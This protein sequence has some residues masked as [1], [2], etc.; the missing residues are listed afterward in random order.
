MVRR[1]T[2][3]S[4]LKDVGQAQERAIEVLLCIRLLERLADFQ[5]AK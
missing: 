1:A 4:L 2:V 5:F 3:K